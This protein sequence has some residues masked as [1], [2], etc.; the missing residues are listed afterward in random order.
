MIRIHT[1]A[2]VRVLDGFTGLALAPSAVRFRVDGSPFTPVVKPGGYYVLTGLPVGEHEVVLQA[3]GFGPERL[4]IVG[5]MREMA[6][7][8]VTLK[9]GEGYRF[10]SSVTWM[11]IHIRTAKKEPAPGKR[12]W[13]AAK[14]PIYELRIAQATL[15]K[16]ATTGRLFYP[17]SMRAVSLPRH[18]LVVDGERSE[19]VLLNELDEAQ[20]ADG[21]VNDHKRGRCLYPAQVYTSNEDGDI[22]AVF[23]NPLPLEILVEGE[24]KPVSFEMEAGENE[25]VIAPGKKK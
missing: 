5:G 25:T 11:T 20:F 13:I 17:P 15:A 16:G 14:N 23:Q 3:N 2:V 10:Q 19:V 8:L 6:D 18:F 21:L 4:T 9:P 22:R 7:L 1:N 24:K 12:V